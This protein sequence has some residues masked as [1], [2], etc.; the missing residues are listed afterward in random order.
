MDLYATSVTSASQLHQ[1]R[2]F[3][4]QKSDIKLIAKIENVKAIQNFDEILEAADGIMIARGYLGMELPLEQIFVAQKLMI[5]KCNSASKPVITAKQ[6]LESMNVYPRPTRAEATDVCNAVLDGTDAV[7]LSN[8]TALGEYPIE[9]VRYMR[10]M[11][12]EGER[13]EANY[14]YTQNFE[15]LRNTM[16][17]NPNPSIRKFN[18]QFC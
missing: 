8:E 7:M 3:L 18:F 5:S 10:L 4:G 1:I 15:T 13:V 2:S 14:D 11:C 16:L 17:N 12:K 6:M 9:S